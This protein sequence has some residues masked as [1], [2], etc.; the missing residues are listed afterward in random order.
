M[1]ARTRKAH[2]IKG[3]GSS[4]YFYKHISAR[5]LHLFTLAS[6]SE[7]VYS[8]AHAW[9][10]GCAHL[11]CIDVNDGQDYCVPICR[12]ECATTSVAVPGA[13][14]HVHIT[15]AEKVHRP[16]TSAHACKRSVHWPRPKPSAAISVV[17]GMYSRLAFMYVGPVDYDAILR[18]FL[19]VPECR[20]NASAQQTRL[21]PIQLNANECGTWWYISSARWIRHILACKVCPACALAV[22]M[23]Q[24]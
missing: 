16:R 19:V 8:S 21:Q 13:A 7:Q 12:C 4:R 14:V 17:F 6:G 20:R 11:E 1:R 23:L 3:L 22:A 9:S 18:G 5:L 15:S 10:R 2:T 24:H